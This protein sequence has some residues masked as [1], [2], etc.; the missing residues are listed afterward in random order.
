M[1]KEV[2]CTVEERAAVRG[3][4]SKRFTATW[5]ELEEEG[6]QMVD[7]LTHSWNIEMKL[8]DRQH[9]VMAHPCL[10]IK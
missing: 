7:V 2:M 3:D 10:W 9:Q 5:A 6:G 1:D 8:W 4:G